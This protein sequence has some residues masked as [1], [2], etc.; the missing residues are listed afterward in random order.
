M[1]NTSITF[2]ILKPETRA[3]Q[4]KRI[5]AR[6]SGLGFIIKRE[7]TCTLSEALLLEHYKKHVGRDFFKP[8]VDYL[9][10]GEVILLVLGRDDEQDPVQELRLRA[11]PTDPKK[12]QSITIRYEFGEHEEAVFRNAIHASDSSEEAMLEI[13]RFFPNN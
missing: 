4:H 6:L 12:C 11:G 1:K 10:S 9:T 13:E 5:K 3:L 2:A 8:M 7:E